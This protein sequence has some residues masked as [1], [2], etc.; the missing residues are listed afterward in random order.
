MGK[1]IK[2]AELRSAGG[3]TTVLGYDFQ[4]LFG[5]LAQ[6]DEADV[7]I[8]SPEDGFSP[9][10]ASRRF[11]E[12]DLGVSYS[13]H[14]GPL[15]DWNHSV[16]TRVTLVA[17]PSRNPEGRLRGVILA[18]GSNSRSYG[19]Y[20]RSSSQSPNRS[21]YYN[22]AYEAIAFVCRQWESRRIAI[23][24]LCGGRRFHADM[25]TCQAEALAHFCDSDPQVAPESFVFCGCCITPD[26]LKGIQRL[27]AE[28][29]ISRHIPIHVEQETTAGV[30][31]L[32]L[33]WR[34]AP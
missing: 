23:S 28:S 25:A 18:P 30:T 29:G 11:F 20:S 24:H 31:L 3:G 12:D 19:T 10:G 1:F 17:I 22:V 4:T 7:A 34:R 14:V 9:L 33:D 32:H 5:E 8:V 26:H 2:F 13:E 21:F 6:R 27:N 16:N 15:A